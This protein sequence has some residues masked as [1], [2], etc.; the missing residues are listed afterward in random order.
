MDLGRLAY[1]RQ[2]STPLDVQMYV[3]RFSD[4]SNSNH[5]R[6]RIGHT[7]QTNSV[8]SPV[9]M[10]DLHTFGKE[11]YVAAD[12]IQ[13]SYSL[14]IK[15]ILILATTALKCTILA[16][17]ITIKSLLHINLPCSKKDIRNQVALVRSNFNFYFAI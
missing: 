2:H 9:N 16:I 12:G 7:E 11:K 3:Y 1:K 17:F 4:H 5:C 8:A 14:T 15:N 10:D 6:I 13:R